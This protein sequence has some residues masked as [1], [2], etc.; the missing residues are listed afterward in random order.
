MPIITFYYLNSIHCFLLLDGHAELIPSKFYDKLKYQ[1]K[2]LTEEIRKI[3]AKSTA[4]NGNNKTDSG[5]SSNNSKHKTGCDQISMCALNDQLNRSVMRMWIWV[6]GRAA[7]VTQ[8]RKRE[9]LL[10]FFFSSLSLFFFSPSS[11]RMCV[12]ASR[13]AVLVFLL[14]VRST[15]CTPRCCRASIWHLAMRILAV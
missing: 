8:S 2:P 15:C 1:R 9:S 7:I 3:V 6:C 12:S 11:A 5:G 4:P 13:A 10:F 14:C